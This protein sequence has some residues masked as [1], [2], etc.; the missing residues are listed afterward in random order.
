MIKE[1]LT[2]EKLKEIL[3][4]KELEQFIGYAEN[5]FFDAK[6]DFYNLNDSKDKHEMC[7]D[8]TAFANNDGGYLLIGCETEKSTTHPIDYIKNADGISDFPNMDS[9]YSILSEYVYPNSI[10]TFVGFE[11]IVTEHEKRFL[12]ITISKN[13][14]EKLYFVRKDPQNREFIAYYFRTYD[15]GIRFHIEYLHE[16]AHQGIYFEKYLKNITGAT[17]K[18]LNNTEKLLGKTHKN[19]SLGIHYDIKKDL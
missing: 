16:L 2:V 15:R 10:G 9:M 13:S 6:K 5:H 19:F 18:T 12:L 7:K 4:S 11:H 17:E 8:I 14:E 1:P 3:K